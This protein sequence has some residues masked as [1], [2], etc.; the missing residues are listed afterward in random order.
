MFNSFIQNRRLSSDFKLNFRSKVCTGAAVSLAEH[1]AKTFQTIKDPYPH[2]NPVV[3]D[4]EKFVFEKFVYLMFKKKLGIKMQ[5][6]IN[7]RSHRCRYM[8]QDFKKFAE[9]CRC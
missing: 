8:Y 3:K 1:S 5:F 9:F 2:S 4:F 7:S 6:S